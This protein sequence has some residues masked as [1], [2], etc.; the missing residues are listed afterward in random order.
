METQ[1]DLQPVIHIIIAD[2]HTILAD[3]IKTL[4]SKNK[5]FNVIGT[6][7]DGEE[8][9]TLLK[10]HEVDIVI[11]DINMPKMDGIEATQI[12]SEHFQDTKVLIMSMHNKEGYIQNAL[13]AGA[14]GYIL[15]NTSQEEMERAIDRVMNGGS[16]FSQDV[17]TSMAMKMRRKTD[18]EEIKL[19]KVEKQVLQLLSEGFT[20]DE[21]SAKM[22]TSSNTISS[23][24]RN[25]L[26]KFKAKNVTQLIAIALK[27]GYIT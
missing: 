6:A 27:K 26:L 21:I 8:V 25:M 19:S 22:T 23:Y 17:S 2:D 9:L 18:E 24:R 15:K 16:Y 20:S 12:I 1:E 5:R 14:D 11:M 7:S 4:L 10:M 13:E 3:G